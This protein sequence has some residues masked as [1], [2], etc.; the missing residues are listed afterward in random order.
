MGRLAQASRSPGKLLWGLLKTS[1]A[2]HD[3]RFELFDGAGAFYIP[4]AREPTQQLHSPLSRQSSRFNN[5]RHGKC[6]EYSPSECPP[7]ERISAELASNVLAKQGVFY[8]S[9][10]SFDYRANSMVSKS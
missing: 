4:R 6:A 1:K 9:K 8:P 3:L 2:H 7:K 10:T 5:N